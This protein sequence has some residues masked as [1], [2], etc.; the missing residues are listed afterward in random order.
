MTAF[1][2]R[3]YEVNKG[4]TDRA[5]QESTSILEEAFPGNK[6]LEDCVRKVINRFEKIDYIKG[7]RPKVAIFGDLYVCDNDVM[8][9]ALTRTIEEAGG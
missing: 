1:K 3:P 2:I 9:Q 5:I 7:N 8:N 6:P 4:D